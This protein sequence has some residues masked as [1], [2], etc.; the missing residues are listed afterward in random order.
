MR[1]RGA[2]IHLEKVNCV[3]RKSLV[4]RSGVFE[5]DKTALGFMVNSPHGFANIV[6]AKVSKID[7]TQQVNAIP[8]NGP[9]HETS[10][11]VTYSAPRDMKIGSPRDRPEGSR[12]CPG[13]PWGILGPPV[14]CRG[15]KGPQNLFFHE[16][17]VFAG[18][19]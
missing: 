15:P 18:D 12:G 16:I 2:Q 10:V 11:Y 6:L 5:I 14:G 3:C 4:S 9:I 7:G 1:Y 19:Q 8:K 13:G 17:D